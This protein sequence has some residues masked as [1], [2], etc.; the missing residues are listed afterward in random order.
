MIEPVSAYLGITSKNLIVDLQ[1][2]DDNFFE[3]TPSYH[4]DFVYE[5]SINLKFK[6]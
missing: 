1:R 3:F 2:L 5:R 4:I 6:K